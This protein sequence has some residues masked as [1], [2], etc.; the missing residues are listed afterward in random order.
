MK[1]LDL[2][3][4]SVVAALAVVFVVGVVRTT[5]PALAKG[6]LH[7]IDARLGHVGGLSFAE[8]EAL[9]ARLRAQ[10]S[11][12]TDPARRAVYSAQ[13]SDV[14]VQKQ[15]EAQALAEL[16][17]ALRLFPER[18]ELLARAALL[19]FALGQRARAHAA[20]QGARKHAPDL[21]VVQRAAAI[22][23]GQAP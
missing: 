20:L 1:R 4:G 10:R 21:P 19:Y 11:A 8:S 3:V 5:D 2:V 15:Q 17:E 12:E 7:P 9:L 14:L 22:I 23:E 6:I 18:P 13:L 16:D